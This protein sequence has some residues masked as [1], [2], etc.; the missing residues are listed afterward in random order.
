M[1]WFGMIEEYRPAMASGMSRG[2]RELFAAI[3][4]IIQFTGGRARGD[5]K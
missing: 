5:K 1:R 2:G 4:R 3:K